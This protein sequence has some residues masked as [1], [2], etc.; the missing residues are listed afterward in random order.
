MQ[1]KLGMILGR[2]QIFHKGHQSII[3]KALELCDEVLILIGSSDKS[4]TM[5]NPFTY[6]MRESIIRSIYNDRV[7]IAPLP[8]L[9]VGNVPA[10]GDYVIEACKAIKGV[11]DC[12]I[13]GEEDKCRDWYKNYPNIEYFKVDR[14]IIDISSTSLKKMIIDNEYEAAKKYLAPEVI[15]RYSDIRL[16]LITISV[17]EE[18]KNTLPD[19][20]FFMESVFDD[21]EE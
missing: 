8:D 15:K 4:G 12:V 21:E 14:G 3:D 17:K 18:K 6:E 9:G 20:S 13:Y 16:K 10:W 19:Y 2:F 7:I 1:Y 11:P 5:E